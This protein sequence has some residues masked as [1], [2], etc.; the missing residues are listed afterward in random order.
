[1]RPQFGHA[2]FGRRE[3]FSTTADEDVRVAFCDAEI[4]VEGLFMISGPE[5]MPDALPGLVLRL[6]ASILIGDDR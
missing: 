1:M 4:V 3:D 2:T 5:T 6:L